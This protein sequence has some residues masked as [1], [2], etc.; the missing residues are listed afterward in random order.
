MNYLMMLL[1]ALLLFSGCVAT[2]ET[3]KVLPHQVLVKVSSLPAYNPNALY[4]DMSMR[5]AFKVLEDGTIAE[6]RVLKSPAD[7]AWNG[8][9]AELMKQWRFTTVAGGLE[10]EGQWIQYSLLVHV[11]EPIMMTIGEIVAAR[12]EEAD[13]LYELLDSDVPF[14]SIAKQ[15]A[16]FLGAVDIAAY[17]QNVRDA[18]R[19]LRVHHFTRPL[20]L[21]N[22]YVIYMRFEDSRNLVQ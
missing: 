8:T 21:G 4:R 20:R 5:V 1:S 9:A 14:D 17:P 16:R 2:Q 15:R 18:L 12:K 3:E 19:I 7:P 13:S 22:S 6:V 11:E 10:P